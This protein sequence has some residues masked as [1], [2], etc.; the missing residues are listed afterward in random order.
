M[1]ATLPRYLKANLAL[2]VSTA[3]MIATT[4]PCGSGGVMSNIDWSSGVDR[5][6]WGR[7]QYEGEHGDTVKSKVRRDRANQGLPPTTTVVLPKQVYKYQCPVCGRVYTTDM[8]LS[9]APTCSSK[10]THSRVMKLIET[11]RSIPARSVR[12]PTGHVRAQ[13]GSERVVGDGKPGRVAPKGSTRPIVPGGRV[14]VLG[15]GKREDGDG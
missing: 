8:N 7:F 3:H 15:K 11:T 10:G 5:R 1:P 2:L 6:A 12:G 9:C 4:K 13:D 14:R